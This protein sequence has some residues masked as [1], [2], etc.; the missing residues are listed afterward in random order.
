MAALTADVHIPHL[1]TP[2]KIAVKAV[3][4]DTFY[5]GALV[6]ADG[7]TGK[8]QVVPAATDSFLGI[9]AAQVVATAADDLVEIYVDGIWAL[10]FTG[11]A[12]VDVGQTVVVD[13]SGGALSDNEADLVSAA[14][15]TIV[16]GDILIGKCI[17]INQEDTSR[18]WVQLHTP[19]GIANVLG[20]L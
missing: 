9:C 2:T 15:A 17:G 10:A 1:G 16:A 4:A 11:V 12:E 19:S 18:G 13:M 6:F 7:T 20:W 14:D 3:A 5:A 8:A